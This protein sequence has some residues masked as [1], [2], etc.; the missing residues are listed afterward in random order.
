MK[1]AIRVALGARREDVLR[2]VLMEGRGLAA[3]GW[4]SVCGLARELHA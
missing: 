4:E 3:I 1:S 2:Q